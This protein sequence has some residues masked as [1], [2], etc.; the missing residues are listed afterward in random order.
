M[1]KKLKIFS[2]VNRE[3]KY[4]RL[5]IESF[6]KYM[7]LPEVEFIIINGSIDHR[8]EVNQIC[9]EE[10]IKTEQYFGDTSLSYLD[11][12]SSHSR[13]FVE[14]IVRKSSDHALLIHPDMFFI[15]SID[16]TELLSEKKIMFIPRYHVGLFYIWEGTILMDCEFLN[17]TGLID[18]FDIVGFMKGPQGNWSDGGGVS[19]RFLEKMNPGDYG[20]FE[21]WN[22]H[23]L[24]GEDFKTNLNGHASYNFN[25]KGRRIH[26]NESG[27]VGPALGD[28]TY[29]YENVEGNYEE[30]FINNFVWI[31]DNFVSGYSFPRPIHIDIICK[32]G[33][34]KN[35]FLIHFKSG[36]GYQDFFNFD[37][38]EQKMNALREV[39]C[40]SNETKID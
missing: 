33:D 3:V 25:L 39:I 11:Y 13:W 31:R 24:D 21:F 28:R 22:L 20:F 40:N 17:S 12:G 35:P 2:L 7:N 23:D 14:N 1:G 30:Y 10:G 9:K 5:Q 6:K 37:Y 34:L 29:E 26:H 19:S 15:S 16:H 36:S 4:T 38:Q 8:D 18:D 27:L 32:A